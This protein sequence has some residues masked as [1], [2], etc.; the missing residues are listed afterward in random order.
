MF[1]FFIPIIDPSIKEW[2]KEARFLRWLTFL[3]LFLGIIALF[4]AS[5]HSAQQ[6]FGNGFHY[7]IRQTIWIW[8]GL[9]GF[10]II[11]K[12]P[13]KYLMKFVP[14]FIFFLL[15]LI[16]L[17]KTGLGHT[18]NGATRW[19]KI[20]PAIIQ[21]SE[22]IKPFLVLQSAYIFGFWHRHSLRIKIQWILIF[23]A[24]LAGILIQPNLSTTALCGISLWLIALASGIPVRY[25][26]TADAS[27]LSAASFSVYTHRYQLKRILSFLDPWKDEIAKTDGYQL[28]Q[29]LIA[30]GSGGIFGLGYGQS[31]Q[32]WS[33][34]PIHYTDFIFSVYAEEFGFIGSIFLLLLLFVYAT[35]T[36]KILINCTHPVKRLIAVGSMIMMVG[37]ALLNI[38]VTIGLLPTT[39]LPLPLWSYGGSSIIASLTLSGLLIRVIIENGEDPIVRID[40]SE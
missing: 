31:I 36:L 9:Q 11:V 10:N 17:T 8:I 6:D 26:I 27:G 21:P 20:G 5:Y 16:L 39:G 2:S 35:F 37:Q 33:Y 18:V 40:K 3:W 22:L 32:K 13:L 28:I 15:S 4:S 14:F 1:N 29:S 23:S 25:L 7:I 38:G 30:V 12:M 24:V 19:I 34:L